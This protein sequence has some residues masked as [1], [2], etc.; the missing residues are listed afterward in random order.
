M[1]DGRP[2]RERGEVR[3][4]GGGR[5]E[6]ESWSQRGRNSKDGRGRLPLTMCA[7]ITRCGNRFSNFEFKL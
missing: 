5:E 3:E 4:E 6:E 2:G 7:C 1:D